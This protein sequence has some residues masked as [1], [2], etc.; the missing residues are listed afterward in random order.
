MLYGSINSKRRLFH[1]GSC[2]YAKRTKEQNR[3]VFE[4]ISLAKRRGFTQCPYCNRIRA[5]YR[6]DQEAITSLCN[7]FHLLPILTDD[8][9]YVISQGDTAWRIRMKDD[10]SKQR[11]L[12]HES[13]SHVGYNRKKTAYEYREYHDQDVRTTNICGYL[14]YIHKHDI[15]EAKR[16]LQRQQEKQIRKALYREQA[17]SIHAAHTQIAK[18][19]RKVKKRVYEDDHVWSRQKNSKH[20]LQEA[21]KCLTDYQSIM[22]LDY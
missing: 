3:Q 22:F 7:R 21:A 5:E 12:L 20:Y 8:E 19:S 13:K 1:Y 10:G 4:T 18:K 9:L 16:N 15:F 11:Q 14:S 17:I 6:K 2:Q